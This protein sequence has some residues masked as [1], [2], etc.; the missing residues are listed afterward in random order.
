MRLMSKLA[1]LVIGFLVAGIPLGGAFA[2]TAPAEI[3]E[4]ARALK[5]DPDLIYEYVYDNIE[6]IPLYGSAKGPLGA[7]IDGKG[8]AV[9]QA[10]LMVALL[11]QAAI[12]NTAITNPQYQTGTVWLTQAQL[13]NWLGVDSSPS[14]LSV[15]LGTAGIPGAL[16][17]NAGAS[18]C[19]IVT[20]TWVQV[21]ISGQ[22]VVFDPANKL[23]NQAAADLTAQGPTCLAHSAQPAAVGYNRV[24]GVNLATATGYV[25][26]SFLADARTGATVTDRSV[27]GLN[28]TNVRNDLSTY[29]TNL[30]NWIR[31]NKPAASPNDILGGKT[32][33]PLPIGLHQR[34]AA[35][36]YVC[37]SVQ[38]GSCSAATTSATIP[39]TLRTTLSV[40][41]PGSGAAVVFNSSDIYGHR[42]TVFFNGSNQPVLA[43]DG[44]TEATGSAVSPGTNIALT[45]SITH[46]SA[47]QNQ[48][49]QTL[50]VLSGGQ[51]V[52]ANGW[53]GVSR[54][55]IE[56]HRRLLLQ[57]QQANPGQPS[58]EAVLGETISVMANTWM[59]EVNQANDL[60]QKTTGTVFVLPHNVG[61][62]GVK[63]LSGGGSGPFVDL[64][65]N[66]LGD[67]QL[68]GR[69]AGGATPVETSAFYVSA[70]LSS[71]FESGIIEQTQPGVAAVSTVKL[72]DNASQTDTIYDINNSGVAGD[73]AA[74]WTS[75]IK[76]LFQ[77]YYTS[78]IGQGD[79]NRINGLVVSNNLRVIAALH[80]PVTISQWA[81]SGYF[82]ITQDGSSIGSIISGGLSG[83][84]ATTS[85]P[86][87]TFNG[88][89]DSLGFTVGS[90]VGSGVNN[91][92]TA[93]SA[94]GGITK[95]GVAFGSDPVNLVSGA[96]TSDRDDLSVGSDAAPYSLAFARHYDSASRLAPAGPLGI[97]WTH[98][99]FSSAQADSDGFAGMAS[100]SPISGAS[101]IAAAYVLEDLLNGGANAKPLDKIIIAVQAERWLMDQ[102]TGNV[103][104]VIEGGTSQQYVKLADSTY[105]APL[106]SN[107]NLTLSGGLY[108]LK[109]ADQT[110]FNFNSDGNLA[111]I[112]YPSGPVITLSYN[113]AK[114]L[115]SVANGMG[116]SLT[117]SYT[118]SQITGVTDGARSVSYTYDASSN[119]TAFHDPAGASVTYAYDLPGR[120]TQIFFPTFPT[121]ATVS[122]TYSALDRVNVQ[123]DANGNTTSLFLA[124]YR[125]ETDDAAGGVD[126]VYLTP[127]GDTKIHI[128]AV[129]SQGGAP[130]HTTINS[131]DGI[132]RLASTTL[133]EGN[134]VTYAYDNVDGQA[135]LQNVL[136]II[137][138]PKPGSGAPTLTRSFTYEPTFNHVKTATDALG[139]VTTYVY[140]TAGGSGNLLEVDQPAVGGLVSKTFFSYNSRGQLLTTADPTGKVTLNTYDSATEVLLSVT[141]DNV[142]LKLKTQFGYDTA[143]DV[144][145][146]TDPNGAV[147]TLLYDPL[148]RVTQVTGPASTG[149]VT[150]TFYDLDGRVTQV[151]RATGVSATPWQTISATFTYSGKKHTD[152]DANGN[153][154][155]Y[156]YDALDR[157]A[158]VTDAVN[159]TTTY[160]YD[161]L[162]RL[163]T[164]KNAGVQAAPLAQYSY[165]ANGRRKT[166]SDANGNLTTY[167]YDGLDRVSSLQYPVTTRG[168]GLSDAANAESYTYDLNGNALSHTKRDGSV[169]TATYDALNRLSTKQYPGHVND[170]YLTYDLAGRLLSQRFGGLT[171]PGAIYGYDTAGRMTSESTNGQAM[172]YA[173]DNVGNRTKVT[174]P[175]GFFVTYPVDAL[176]RVTSINE[177]GATSGAGVLAAY[178]Y[179][180]LSRRTSATLGDTA[181]TGYGYDPGG[182]LT[183]LT[184]AMPAAA[185][186]ANQSLSLAYTAANQLQSR[187]SDNSSYEWA[188]YAT[189]TTNST[190]D[191]LNRDAA[192]AA[193]NDGYDRSGN[194]T[195]DGAR[196]FS[197]DFDNRLTG[198]TV[199]SSSTNVTL[200][201]DSAGRLRQQQSTVGAAAPV[202]TQFLYDGERLVAEY[203]SSGALLRRYVHGLGTDEPI[204]WY[205]GAG[206]S[207]R[208]WLHAD[209]RG[210]VVAYSRLSGTAVTYSYGPYGE[211]AAWGGT[212]F[213][214]TGQIQI[215]EI[216][217]Y[218]YKGRAYD[219][220]SGRFLQP[221][222]IGYSGG[223]NLY[224]YVGNDPLDGRDPSGLA[225]VTN[226]D[227]H[228]CIAA[229]VPSGRYTDPSKNATISPI[230]SQVAVQ[231]GASFQSTRTTKEI[232]G[233]GMAGYDSV[234]IVSSTH[235][236]SAGSDQA[237][238]SVP[239]SA[240]FVEHGHI[241]GQDQGMVDAP[242]E[243]GK[244]YGLGDSYGL[245][246]GWP[247]VTVYGD[248]VGVRI[249]A[250]GQ[251]VFQVLQGNPSAAD[252]TAIGKNL[253]FEQQQ[254]LLPAGS[255]APHYGDGGH[256]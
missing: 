226:C 219:P 76:P 45:V 168:T 122:N 196:K 227:G 167:F 77:G 112:Q 233:Y 198:A 17:Q 151:Q 131:Y 174:W 46:P 244:A 192:I 54:G 15:V 179:D 61:I 95:I 113:G 148:R 96:F 190:A 249:V 106:K 75:T 222:P 189:A 87:L 195:D 24:T 90:T 205:E 235:P 157:L 216:Q 27:A 59:A 1:A 93:T 158:A 240:V 94:G 218:H 99:F 223:A 30:V 181:S 42:L 25:A 55:M 16:V 208:R 145:S 150:K 52:I 234:Q 37:T 26:S 73:T 146:V 91:F 247:V 225:V 224:A 142:N 154:T 132:D 80:G 177:N 43:L 82:E 64:P 53:G 193:L 69:P 135:A 194:L 230:D 48:L 23:S 3:V 188:G 13:A 182:R 210:S 67:L 85:I 128:D 66:I 49:S 187:S 102:I 214:Y 103:V 255:P 33:N 72:L 126:V 36:P 169:I 117:L 209:E 228:I 220:V 92:G 204:V 5:N 62:A 251:L 4:L 202:T 199:V 22:T 156:T 237:A 164:A 63:G 250:Q 14:T 201:Y 39:S 215:A 9:D 21:T 245:T 159:R 7:L 29:S 105:N 197:Y 19:A 35:I 56:R 134:G 133:P 89:L 86:P 2:Q 107:A 98:N 121:H 246:K 254:F 83:G 88:N 176:N 50:N 10:E 184:R 253:D 115:T 183:S 191:G 20:E 44:V 84:F 238:A 221:D 125:A 172:T 239:K 68:L 232:V 149:V 155:T 28:R 70:Q 256:T 171:G 175:D 243:P 12:N 38:S 129:A 60:V 41:V 109:A 144:N 252:I 32:V 153:V 229:S 111:T 147:S 130:L 248:Q 180:P 211:P 114:Q 231:N 139:A 152:T 127:Q 166:V 242:N 120:L 8:T 170:I 165:S 137:E 212:R 119:L 58:I 160:G 74:Y 123:Q 173:Y 161:A 213:A 236:D 6:T 47:Y 51:Y 81:G 97:G 178:A 241:A 11:Q 31:V 186:A 138:T 57:A 140:D 34:W 200:A 101:A 185:M 203:D 40:N 110:K 71:V 217:L 124:G 143:G 108:I 207:D 100:N 163:L 78:S 162:G 136:S 116:R 141:D 206:A 118:G 18:V 104:G 79:L 65:L